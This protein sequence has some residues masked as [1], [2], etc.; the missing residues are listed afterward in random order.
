MFNQMFFVYITT[1]HTMKI[2]SIPTKSYPTTFDTLNILSES[3]YAVVYEDT[4]RDCVVKVIPEEHF[5]LV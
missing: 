3:E 2:S 1:Q 5:D 4:V